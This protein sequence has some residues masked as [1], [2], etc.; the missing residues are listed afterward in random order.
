MQAKYSKEKN[1][2]LIN[3]EDIKKMINQAKDEHSHVAIFFDE[4]NNY[5]V[6]IYILN[7][8]DAYSEIITYLDNDNIKIIELYNLYMNIE[9]QLNEKNAFHL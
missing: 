1:K 6:P 5:I 3:I 8:Q 2:V 4:L 9:K 7:T